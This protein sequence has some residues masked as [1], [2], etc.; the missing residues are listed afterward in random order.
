MWAAAVPYKVRFSVLAR[1]RAGR[2]QASMWA[3][4]GRPPRGPRP[5]ARSEAGPSLGRRQP[6]RWPVTGRWDRGSRQDFGGPTP[7]TGERGLKMIKTMDFVAN[8]MLHT[9]SLV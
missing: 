9:L 6:H 5:P 4:P 3:A 8:S 2:I 1:W 7:W